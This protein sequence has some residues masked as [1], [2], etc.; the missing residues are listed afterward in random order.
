MAT[1]TFGVISNDETYH[2]RTIMQILG[3]TTERAAYERLD[4]L[5]VPYRRFRGGAFIAGRDFNMAIQSTSTLG[6]YPEESE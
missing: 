1:I 3:I 5:G 4:H 6:G 2:I